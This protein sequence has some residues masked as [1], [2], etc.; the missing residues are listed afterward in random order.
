MA[1]QAKLVKRLNM[2]SNILV[3]NGNM[4]TMDP[5]RPRAE[6]VLV[7]G[8]TIVAVGKAR[9]LRLAAPRG[10]RIIDAHGG[11]IVP[12]FCDCHTHLL[13]LG[14]MRDRVSLSPTASLRSVLETVARAAQTSPPNRLMVGRGWCSACWRPAPVLTADML[15]KAAPDNPVVLLAHDGHTAWLNTA[16]LKLAGIDE[17]TPYPSGGII[18]R[19]AGSSRPSG[20]LRENAVELAGST[21]RKLG[22]HE[23]VSVLKRAFEIAHANGITAVHDIDEFATFEA[24]RRLERDGRLALRVNFYVEEKGLAPLLAE[25]IRT[26]WESK[27]LRFGGVKFFADGTLSSQTA[28]MLA[29]F[30]TPG[31]RDSCGQMVTSRETLMEKIVSANSHGVAASVHAIGDAAVR[32]VLDACEAASK[33]VRPVRHVETNRVEHAQLISDED[34]PR[35]VKLGVIASMQPVHMVLD[36]PAAEAHWGKGRSRRAFRFRDLLDSGAGLCFGSD[37]PVESINPLEGLYA[38]VARRRGRPPA[39][40]PWFPAQRLTVDEALQCFTT[41]AARICGQDGRRGMIRPG[42]AADFVV[43]SRDI[44]SGEPIKCSKPAS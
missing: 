41:E 17:H 21:R 30:S 14:L 33:L 31:S 8:D 18:E 11:C 15:D 38:A 28:A 1:L 2:L 5:R 4:V 3:L 27:N 44:T 19:Y 42:Y 35:F 23:R 13:S 20:L 22:V 43:L 32:A 24:Y 7:A 9:S 37:A 26:G 25:G 40:R 10:T 29:P 36:I 16:A 12:G 34:L 6:A 39:G